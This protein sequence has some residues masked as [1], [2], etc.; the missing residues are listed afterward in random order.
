MRIRYTAITLGLATLISVAAL[1][2]CGKCDTTGG[3]VTPQDVDDVMDFYDLDYAYDCIEAGTFQAGEYVDGYDQFGNPV[4]DAYI[5]AR[6]DITCDG[7]SVNGASVSYA[8]D[9]Y[10]AALTVT[11]NNVTYEVG[12]GEEYGPFL[13]DEQL[14]AVILMDNMWYNHP[15]TFWFYDTQGSTVWGAASM[16]VTGCEYITDEEML[17]DYDVVPVTLE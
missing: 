1:T 6:P 8:G 10:D 16:I 4:W 12:E 15:V 11:Y 2:G 3:T 5:V 14:E 13:G 7:I 9:Y 17:C